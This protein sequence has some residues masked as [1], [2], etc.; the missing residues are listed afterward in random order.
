MYSATEQSTGRVVALKKGR[1]SLLVKHTLFQHE[2]AVLKTLHG[3]A[4]IPD[5]FAYGRVQ[6]FELLSMQ[7]YDQCIG[8]LMSE[9]SPLP[10][11][12]V[13]GIMDQLVSLVDDA[14]G[15]L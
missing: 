13:L 14:L 10:V 7:L 2:A 3:H 6:H 8:S 4:A 12:L 5:V 1:V 15:N 9:T 11:P